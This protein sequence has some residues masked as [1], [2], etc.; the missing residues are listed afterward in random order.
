MKFIQA[1][2]SYKKVLQAAEKIKIKTKTKKKQK[3]L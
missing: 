2:N 3:S 1:S